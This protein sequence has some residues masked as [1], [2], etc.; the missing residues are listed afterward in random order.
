MNKKMN[1][2]VRLSNPLFI[3]SIVM[4]ILTPILMYMGITVQDITSWKV[5]GDILLQA[6]ANPYVLGLVV[7]SLYNTCVD[8]TTPGLKDSQKVLEKNDIND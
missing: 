5:L 1:L 7:V 4:S 2:K 3:A 8:F 6:I